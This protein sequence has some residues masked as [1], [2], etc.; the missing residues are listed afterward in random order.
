MTSRERVLDAF[1]HR[2]PDRVPCWCGASPLFLQKATSELGL[3]E[4]G[5]LRRL[6]DD[7]RRLS[8]TYRGP[9][10]PLSPGATSRGPFGVE[11][12]GVGGGQALSHPLAA[13]SS[14]REI[15]DYPWPSADD[16]DVS[17]LRARA[18]AWGGEFAV[19]GGDWSPFWHDAIDLVGME[20]LYFLMYD[21]PELASL[22]FERICDFYIASSERIF[23]EAGDLMDIFFVGNDFGSTTGPL[24][25]PELFARFLSPC[26]RRFAALGHA[27]GLKVMLH[28]C[29]GF[30]PLIPLMIEDGIDALH[31]LQPN[32]A[33]MEPRSLKRDFGASLLLNGCIDSQRTLIEGSPDSVREDTLRTLA[34]MAPGGGYVAGASHDY[35]LPET[36]LENVLA[37]F[38]AIRKFSDAP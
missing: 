9:S 37:M 25:G 15:L 24:V 31:A 13:L 21:E 5:L 1:A 6:G 32:C 22:L 10:P 17:G 2:E 16:V 4:E 18:A 3:D 29:G 28:C 11:R 8:A 33:G 12:A 19:L 38:D 7:F 14:A 30:R 35:I 36:P 27:R 20:G 34:I 26:L 23:E